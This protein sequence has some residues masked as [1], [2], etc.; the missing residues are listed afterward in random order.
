MVKETGIIIQKLGAFGV[1]A[2]R[3]QRVRMVIALE[4]DFRRI[5]VSVSTPLV[6]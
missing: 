5:E 4:M 3:A 1:Y 6:F 2:P